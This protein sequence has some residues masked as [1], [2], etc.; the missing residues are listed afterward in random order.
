LKSSTH[1]NHFALK[2]KL[3]FSAIQ[4]AYQRLNSLQPVRLAA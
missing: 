3:Y 2:S 1:L 4:S